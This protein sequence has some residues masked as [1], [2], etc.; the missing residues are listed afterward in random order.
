MFVTAG[1]AH[2][3]LSLAFREA[4]SESLFLITF[5]A[6][7]CA[8]QIDMVASALRHTC[9][10]AVQNAIAGSLPSKSG[11]HTQREPQHSRVHVLPLQCDTAICAGKSLGLRF[12]SRW[13]WVVPIRII[14]LHQ[15]A[16]AAG[17][18]F[19]GLG[20]P[21]KPRA[22]KSLLPS[23]S[24]SVLRKY[25]AACSCRHRFGQAAVWPPLVSGTASCRPNCCCK[26]LCGLLSG[27]GP[28]WLECLCVGTC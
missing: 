15:E 4:C 12:R 1:A 11:E 24:E 2:G 14:N 7:V 17:G 20:R 22:V 18:S 5:V 27:R 10:S 13:F 6:G 8:S 9:V 28:C 16:A 3:C 21:S 25:V 26:V 23:K 19:S